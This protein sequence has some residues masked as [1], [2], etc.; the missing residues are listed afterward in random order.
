M[1]NVHDKALEKKY[2]GVCIIMPSW[3]NTCAICKTRRWRK[4]MGVVCIMG[5]VCIMAPN[6]TS[7]GPRLLDWLSCQWPVLTY[8]YMCW[9]LDNCWC[10]IFINPHYLPFRILYLWSKIYLIWCYFLHISKKQHFWPA[11]FLRVAAFNKTEGRSYAV[12]QELP[13]DILSTHSGPT[14]YSQISKLE[15]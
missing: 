8:T 1:R 5:G 9:T 7:S 11:R 12:K 4:D 14:R 6:L 10:G 15:T 2:G 3:D 13:R